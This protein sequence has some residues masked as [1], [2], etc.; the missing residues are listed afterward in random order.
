METLIFLQ[1]CL[2]IKLL[3][4]FGTESPGKTTDVALVGVAHHA[5]RC[6]SKRYLY[7]YP[8]HGSVPRILV[9]LRSRGYG[10][11]VERDLPK[12]E[13]GVRF[14]V[15]AQIC[16]NEAMKKTLAGVVVAAALCVPVAAFADNGQLIALYQQ[17]VAILQQELNILQAKALTVTPQTGPAPFTA[18]FTLNNPLGNEA[19][20]FGD[21]H[22]TGSSGCTTNAGGYC[23]L[24]EP[25][26]HVY[27]FPGT[28]T[29]TLYR[30][31]NT[32]AKVVMTTT[33]VVK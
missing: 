28:Y 14:P 24:S 12:V 4:E 32:S 1:Q 8:P 21:G 9:N 20:D 16:Y 3:L 31:A 15:P 29:V 25:V 27:Q 26:T 10:L 7:Q 13:S 22:S 5:C 33:V 2:V 6:T 17:L 30:G 11:V 18:T 23:D 19:I